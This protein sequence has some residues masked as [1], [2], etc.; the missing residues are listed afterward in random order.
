MQPSDLVRFITLCAI[1]GSSFVFIRICAPVF[2]PVVTAAGRL[3]LAGL[4]LLA[5]LR[6]T[7]FDAQWR[8]HR[9]TYFKIGWLASGLP[10]LCFAFGALRL[11]A[12]LLS[13]INACTPLFTAIFAAIWLGEAFGP[14]RIAG[15]ML[16]I[17]GVSL[18]NGFGNVELTPL[19]LFS[20]GVT[21]LGPMFYG[22]SGIY[23][24]RCA[25]QLSPQGNAAW[26]QLSVAPFVF[27]L[28]PLSPPTA[29]P[30]P[31]Q[32]AALAVLA[33]L[34]SGVAYVL[35]YRLLADIGPTRAAT[36]T[37][38]IPIFGMLWG[39]L[40]LGEQ[41]TAGMLTGCGIMISG[42]WLVVGPGRPR[43]L[44]PS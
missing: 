14:K 9:W 29:W 39:A 32:W 19:N 18:A 12:S 31:G 5:Y 4:V 10:F 38:V 11:P 42:T 23:I 7:R 15:M 24:K 8:T 22:L 36:I 28:T 16:G 44:K 13:I 34:C 27:L 30:Q 6:A 2:G 40:F 20:I 35:F 21:L 3:G 26:S 33:I 37:F 43:V 25:S 17:G 41:I 1:W